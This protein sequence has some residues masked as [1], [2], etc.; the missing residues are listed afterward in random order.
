VPVLVLTSSPDIASPDRITTLAPTGDDP[1][2]ACKDIDP[3]DPL[4][5]S[6]VDSEIDDPLRTSIDPDPSLIDGDSDEDDDSDDVEII[7]PEPPN[8]DT[9]DPLLSL[10]SPSD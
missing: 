1:D 8:N 5:L 10:P 2:P 7:T 3:A 9:I 4:P 6:P